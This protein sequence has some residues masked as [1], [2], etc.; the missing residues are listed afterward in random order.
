RSAALA[1]RSSQPTF[2]DWSS[3]IEKVAATSIFDPARWERYERLLAGAHRPDDL[4]PISR[5]S[6]TAPSSKRAGERW[7][8]AGVSGYPA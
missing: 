6:T 2:A 5:S 1:I 3:L 8:S 7:P 4:W